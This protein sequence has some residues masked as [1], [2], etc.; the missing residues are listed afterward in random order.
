V[1]TDASGQWPRDRRHNRPKRPVG[2]PWPQPACLPP[3]PWP[4][5]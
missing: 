2:S 1:L 4:T 3:S 5:T